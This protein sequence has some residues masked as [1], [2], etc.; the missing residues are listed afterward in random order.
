[1]HFGDGFRAALSSI[2]SHKLRSALT[3]IGM[4]IGVLAVVTMFS[5][6]YAIKALVK[7]NMEGMGW[8]YS[9]VI[10]PGSPGQQ[11]NQRSAFRSVRRATQSVQTLNYEDYQALKDNLD[12]KTIYGMIENNALFRRR[13]KDQ[14][15]RLRATENAFFANKSYAISEGRQFNAQESEQ[16][17]AVAIIGY[18]FAQD[19]F[20][21]ENPL[22][23][24]LVLGTHRFQIVGVLGSD[25]LNSGNGM[26]FNQYEREEEM[27]AVYIPLK[28]GV[29][30]F[31]TGKGLHQIYLQAQDEDSFRTMKSR[32]RQLLLSRHNMYPNFMFVDVG[33]LMLTITQEMEGIMEKWSMTLSAIASISLIVGGIG[34]FS[35]LLISIQERMTEIGI[36]KSIG[37]TDADIFIYFIMEAVALALAGA[38]LGVVIAGTLLTLVGSAIKFPLYLPVAG[39]SVG[40]GFSLLIGFLSGLYPALKAAGIDP[41][42]AINSYE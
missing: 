14:Y 34:L 6:I 32:A 29:Y 28:Y 11:T 7:K 37:A 13:N 31:G 2:S 17:T 15:V 12:Y 33:A 24:T 35:T 26:N 18:K 3:L 1:M 30:R 36:R 39:V 21:K 4:V 10:V 20:N 9:I 41:I 25:Q 40:V 19:Q 27:K 8:D 16:G 42:V 22:G 23:K 5:S 38:I